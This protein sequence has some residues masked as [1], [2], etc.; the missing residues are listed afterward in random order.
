MFQD[1]P[2]LVAFDQDA[3]VLGWMRENEPWEETLERFRVLRQSSLRLFLNALPHDLDRYGNHTERGIQ[4][5]TDLVNTLAG[6]DINHIQQ[7]E[8]LTGT[9]RPQ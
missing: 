7:I 1:R 9:T 3:W 2:T 4:T 5:I 6:H 8:R